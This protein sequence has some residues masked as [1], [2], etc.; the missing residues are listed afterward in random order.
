[1]KRYLLYCLL[2]GLLYSISACECYK[3]IIQAEGWTSNTSMDGETTQYP[4]AIQSYI[5][6]NYEGLFI[7][8]VSVEQE[9]GN[10]VYEVTLDNGTELYFDLNGTFLS[11]DEG[12]GG[13][14]NLT[15]A[16]LPAAA[17]A[18]I[19]TNYSGMAIDRIRQK[20]NGYYEVRF[21][22]DLKIYFDQ[23]GNFLFEDVEEPNI[24]P[25]DLPTAIQDYIAALYPGV[26]IDEAHQSENVVYK[27]KLIDDTELYFDAN[28]NILY[29]E[30][31][32]GEWWEGD[33]N[34][35]IAVAP[36]SLPANISSYIANNYPNTTIIVAEIESNG[37]YEIRLNN[38]L[39]LY[40][41]HLGVFLYEENE[42]ELVLSS[43]QFPDTVTIGDTAT[44]S[45]YIINQSIYPFGTDDIDIVYGVEDEEP[46]DPNA[47]IADDAINLPDNDIAAGDSIPFSITIPITAARF[48]PG[49][50]ITVIWPDVPTAIN[51]IIIGGGRKTIQTT[52]LP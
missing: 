30:T 31:S 26:G 19:N 48:T 39:K 8:A 4:A 27:I 10:N 9:D 16:D 49:A 42:F 12:N 13:G 5:A 15:L 34:D 37:N 35:E 46:A 1:M 11:E 36:N 3:T 22:N 20:S 32:E 52:V 43:L 14:E 24:A 40:F 33:D 23:Q 44:L 28:G 45:G 41:N 21:D 17:A 2:L 47:V 18:Y 29:E 6:A 50:D 7:I 25:A 38:G 51:P